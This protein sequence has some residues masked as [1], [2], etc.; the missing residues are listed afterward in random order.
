MLAFHLLLGIHVFGGSIALLVG[1][2]PMLTRKGSPIHRQAGH[3]FVSALGLA[4]FSAFVL[5]LIVRDRLLLTIAVLTAF[6]VLSG[7][8][9]ARF[10]H[11]ARPGWADDAI[12]LLLACF[13][14][15]LLWRTASPPEATGLFFGAGSLVLAARHWRLL[16][17]AQ[18]DWLLA[19][20]AGMGGAYIATVTAFMVVNVG[21]L[22]KP[23][24]FI[25][26]TIIG[27]I[28]ITWASTRHA[29]P[30]GRI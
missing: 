10:R 20:L 14:A 9:S 25:V 16:H 12:C 28:L 1:P 2:V 27:T 15:W 4:S 5:A 6:L 7:L 26:P 23:V 13:G 21:F 22:P 17:A 24:V 29:T 11:A 18:P 19:H 8:R 30:A 3:V